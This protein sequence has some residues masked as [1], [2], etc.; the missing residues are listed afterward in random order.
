VL[1]S[2][3]QPF[4]SIDPL[5]VPV[6]LTFDVLLIGIG[7]SMEEENIFALLEM[8]LVSTVELD[9][10]EDGHH[11][12]EKAS[13]GIDVIIFFKEF[14]L[15]KLSEEPCNGLIVDCGADPF[16]VLLKERY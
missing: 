7:S 15:L 4:Q 6:I 14:C 16:Q 2:V 8:L 12:L 5:D 10:V 1:N 11:L 13:L 9:A 3:I